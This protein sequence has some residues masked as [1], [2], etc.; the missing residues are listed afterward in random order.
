[1]TIK[2]KEGNEM[3]LKYTDIAESRF[4]RAEGNVPG[5]IPTE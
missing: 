5:A 4:D 2:D 3:T 1:M